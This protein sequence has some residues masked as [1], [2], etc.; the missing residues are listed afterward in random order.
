MKRVRPCLRIMVTL[1][2]S[3][4]GTGIIFLPGTFRVSGIISGN[5]LSTLVCVLAIV[6]I[7]LLVKCCQGKETLGELAE[8]VWGRSGLILVDTS[9]FFS[10]L[11]FSTVYMIFVSHNIQE[12]IY[13]IS[14]CQIEIPILKLICFQMVIY[15][16]FIFLRDIENLGFPSVLANI[17]VFSVLGVIIYYGFQNLDRYP[18]GRPGIS[19][20]GSIYG[21]GLVLGTSAFNYEGIALI[22]PIRSSTPEYLL[23]A[24][25]AILTFTMIMIGVFSNFFASFVYYSFGDDTAS[26]VTE[27]ILNPK[28][29]TISL[30]IYSA[31][32]MFSVPLQLFPSMGII[33]KYMFQIKSPFVKRK[34]LTNLVNI[35]TSPAA[36]S[37]EEKAT[38]KE[39]EKKTFKITDE[40]QDG[41]LSTKNI[42]INPT[43]TNSIKASQLSFS[44]LKNSE[45]VSSFQNS[46]F[47]TSKMIQ[48]VSISENWDSP[49]GNKVVYSPVENSTSSRKV[50]SM[51]AKRQKKSE[52]RTV[53]EDSETDIGSSIGGDTSNRSVIRA[54]KKESLGGLEEIEDDGGQIVELCQN[55]L[56][57]SR[58][59]FR[60]SALRALVSYSLVLLCGTLAY[61]FEDELGSFV[62]ITGG[63]LCVPLAFVYP[64]LFYFSLNKERIS[65][66]RRIFIGFMVFIGSVISFSS[67]TMAILSWETNPRNLACII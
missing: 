47:S 11:G 32:I 37:V 26:P 33:E 58:S 36:K 59:K 61:N 62:T 4:I 52:K 64:P 15:L 31:A 57:D 19:K 51:E 60:H 63:L 29:K 13:S 43:T 39:I 56:V 2:K 35:E 27:N 22:L 65:K 8:R 20:L 50:E 41:E 1:I 54:G 17:S 38:K 3:F 25:P 67:V 40:K 30:I 42:R 45:N 49:I 18:L 53:I 14:S 12:I 7:R 23:E 24:F 28:A 10:Q 16:P 9:I 48:L 5:I 55:S 6:S 44:S 34:S 46:L 66:A 21:A